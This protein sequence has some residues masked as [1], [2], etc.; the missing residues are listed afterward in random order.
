MG[1]RRNAYVKGEMCLREN[2]NSTSVRVYRTRLIFV[3]GQCL[4]PSRER[5]TIL[6]LLRG[7]EADLGW[8]TED[9]VQQLLKAWGWAETQGFAHWPLEAFRV[10]P[11]ES[12]MAQVPSVLVRQVATLYFRRPLQ[13]VKS[14]Q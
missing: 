3:A 12:K 14:Q 2:S 5:P 10:V 9:R 11:L 7:T 13:Y 4:F 1:C 6:E 8:S